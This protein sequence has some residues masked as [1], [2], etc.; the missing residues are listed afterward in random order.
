M[1]FNENSTN[2]LIRILIGLRRL[3]FFN[4]YM[5]YGHG[6]KRNLFLSS[7]KSSLDKKKKR[8][9]IHCKHFPLFECFIQFKSYV[10]VDGLAESSI[11]FIFFC[12]KIAFNNI[13]TNNWN[14]ML[15]KPMNVFRRD[16]QIKF[17]RQKFTH[18]MLAVGTH[19]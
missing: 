5:Q 9:K 7:S 13:S 15:N 2:T 19:S 6:L 18:K 3:V 8:I 10:W 11:H 14:N 17:A 1:L 16:N 12:R 4:R